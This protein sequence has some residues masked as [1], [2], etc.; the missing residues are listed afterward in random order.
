MN[1]DFNIVLIGAGDSS[2]EF[3]DYLLNDKKFN[4]KLFSIS[5]YDDNFKNKKFFKKLSKKIKLNKIKKLKFI[6]SKNTKYLI[7][8]G[9]IKL[10]K[11]YELILLKKKLSLL[12]LVHSSAQVS[13]TAKIGNG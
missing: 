11:K 4:T 7:T 13:K 8:F 3:A 6:Q 2:I 9:D 10:R 5:V 1:Y 12:K